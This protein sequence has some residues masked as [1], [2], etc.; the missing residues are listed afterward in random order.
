MIM[1]GPSKIHLLLI[2]SESNGLYPTCGV[3][4]TVSKRRALY[5]ESALRSK[6][7][8]AFLRSLPTTERV[9]VEKR[10]G[11]GVEKMLDS[12]NLPAHLYLS[13]ITVNW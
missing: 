6:T 9:A 5:E 8:G 4:F 10:A 11:H 3:L 7:L 1:S 12:W 2:N 13:L